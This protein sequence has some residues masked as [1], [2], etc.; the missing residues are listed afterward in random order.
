MREK[1]VLQSPVI[2]DYIESLSI[3]RQWCEDRDFSGYEPFDGNS[4]PLHFFTFGNPLAERM[5]QQLFRRCRW[6]VRSIFG[7]KPRK[8][9]QGIGYFARGYLNLWKLS[10]TSAYRDR[11]IDCLNWLIK[12][13][14]H[15]QKYCWGNFFPWATRTGKIPARMPTVPWTCLI[16]QAFLDAYESL[17]QKEHLDIAK[18]ICDYILEDVPKEQNGSGI[19]LSYVPLEQRSI[20]NA[21]LLGS[22]MLARTACLANTAD[23]LYTARKAVIFS[24]SKQLQNGGWYYGEEPKHHWIDN[25]HSGY[26]LDSL[27]DYIDYSGDDEFQEHLDKG[28]RFYIDNFFDEE[29]KPK[30][31]HDRLYV[32]DIQ[33]AAQSIDTLAKFADTHP[34]ALERGFQVAK[35]TI[36]HMQ[37]QRGFFYYRNIGN[38]KIKIPMMHW[39]QAT[40]FHALAHLLSKSPVEDEK[41]EIYTQL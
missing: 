2:S 18:S 24:C 5:L 13:S 3:L 41:A 26:V 39:G 7:I 33:N 17:G 15:Q 11:A 9:A 35:W 8:S 19:C 37:D 4:S 20:H 34:D 29:G 22:A 12:H 36:K 10:G 30:F 38:Q 23:L 31:Y 28:F 6:N 16:G 21:N 27:K 14:S 32:V 1:M 25:W 40:M